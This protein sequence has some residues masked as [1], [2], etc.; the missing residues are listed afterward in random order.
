MLAWLASRSDHIPARINP[1]EPTRRGR[2]SVTVKRLATGWTVRGSNSGGGQA[3]P[4][5]PW[6]PF[7]LLYRVPG[8]SRGWSGWVVALTTHPQL[9]PRLKKEQS[10]TST[11]VWA[12]VPFIGWTLPLTLRTRLVAVWNSKSVRDTWWKISTNSPPVQSRL[13]SPC[14]RS[15]SGS[16]RVPYRRVMYWL[17]E[18]QKTLILQFIMHNSVF[19]IHPKSTETNY[20]MIKKWSKQFATGKNISK[21][22]GW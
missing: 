21:M 20:N 3:R 22:R 2:V 1:Q 9:A 11:P 19:I 14:K 12:F 10:Y 15:Y 16:L 6:G 18:R 13:L 4:D 5:R 17:V 7:S 8:L